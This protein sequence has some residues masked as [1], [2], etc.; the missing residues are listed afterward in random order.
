MTRVILGDSVSFSD[1]NMLGKTDE[2]ETINIG[3]KSFS[4]C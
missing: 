3:M 4:N 1:G 2:G